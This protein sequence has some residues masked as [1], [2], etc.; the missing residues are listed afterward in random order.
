AELDRW[1][2][3]RAR[4]GFLARFAGFGSSS[5]SAPLPDS[6]FPRTSARGRLRVAEITLLPLQ[7]EQL[8]GQVELDGRT[9]KLIQG[10]TNFFGGKVSGSLNARL[11]AD[12]RYEFQ[13][14]FDRV[15]LAQLAR[16]LPWLNDRIGGTASGA[17]SLLAHG[18]GRQ[19]LVASIEGQGTLQARN[20]EISGVDFSAANPGGEANP[21]SNLFASVTGAFSIRNGGID[22]TNFVLARSQGRLQADGRIEFSHALNL[23]IRPSV[24]QDASPLASEPAVSF[25]LGGTIEN[26]KFA[27][28]PPPP[29]PAI[30]AGSRRR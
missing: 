7:F 16:A 20:A 18:I 28:S 30:R 24:S 23:L 17:L 29:L 19:S 15:N 10:Q 13:G 6:I 27:L 21:L 12:P 11:V 2:G 1:L 26:P 4:P 9:V 22:L 3:P 8:D 25:L 5:A 14:R